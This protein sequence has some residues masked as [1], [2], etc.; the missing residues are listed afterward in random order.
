[1]RALNSG[2]HV[3]ELLQ[4]IPED[5]L[6]EFSIETS[7][8]HQ[9]KKLSG[10]TMFQLILF[11]MVNRKRISLRVMEEFIRSASFRKLSDDPEIDAKYN[12]LSDRIT[13]INSEFFERIF[14]YVFDLFSKHLGEEQ[15]ICKYDSTMVAISCRLFDWGM[16]VG[17]EVKTDKRQL[18]FSISM[19]GSLPSSFKLFSDQIYLSEDIALKELILD[20][21]K[22]KSGTVV[23]DRGIRS[24]DTFDKFSEENIKFVSRTNLNIVYKQITINKICSKP[25]QATVTIYEDLNVRL[26]SKTKKIEKDF[27]LVKAKIDA[28]QEE[29]YF[30][31]NDMEFSSYEIAEIYKSRWQI[32]TMFKFLKQEMN[33]EHFVSRSENG[34][35]VMMYMSLITAILI[36]ALKKL[37]KISSYKIAK[38]RFAIELENII[39]GQIVIMCGGD[40][41]RF[42]ELFDP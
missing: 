5:V 6:Q 16:K 4:L 12:S 13:H 34:I 21:K 28:T 25:N 31:T 29:I 32:E 30:I 22:N 20:D 41:S 27:R 19:K 35:K 39:I 8:N 23:F 3:K 42:N 36:I 26:K 17:P 38:L 1:M 37:N 40:I 2:M 33:I 24:Y 18:K 14:Y 15:T 7:V 9:V 10:Q 11:S